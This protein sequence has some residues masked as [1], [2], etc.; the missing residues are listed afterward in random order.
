MLATADTQCLP[1]ADLEGGSHLPY[2]PRRAPQCHDDTGMQPQLCGTMHLA[3]CPPKPIL[4]CDACSLLGVHQAALDLQQAIH[5]LQAAGSV[6][7][8]LRACPDSPPVPAL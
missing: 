6:V 8:A 1:V 5:H 7:T 2:L 4:G 3:Q